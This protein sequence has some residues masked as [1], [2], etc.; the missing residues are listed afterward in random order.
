[1]TGAATE[2]SSVLELVRQTRTLPIGARLLGVLRDDG[3]AVVIFNGRRVHLP[4][5]YVR[6]IASEVHDG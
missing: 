4:P 1:V 2:V 5:G 3:S 6:A